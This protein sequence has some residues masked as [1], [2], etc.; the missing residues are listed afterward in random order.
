[1][2]LLPRDRRG[3][4]EIVAIAS[5]TIA[6]SGVIV[7]QLIKGQQP[8]HELIAALI[9]LAMLVAGRGVQSAA[10]RG[11]SSELRTREAVEMQQAIAEFRLEAQQLRRLAFELIE[12]QLPAPPALGP[13][14]PAITPTSGHPY[15]G[16][17]VH[18]PLNDK[19]E[20]QK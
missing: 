18:A 6:V 4:G 16:G 17:E 20:P 7:V 14:P 12:R 11:A 10:E 3:L 13:A 15:R 5:M 2:T 1:M 9:A 8:A 19:K